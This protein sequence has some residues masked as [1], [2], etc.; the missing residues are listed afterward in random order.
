MSTP[1]K[2]STNW[3]I[4]SPKSRTRSTLRRP[5]D[6]Q[7]GYHATAQEGLPRPG[8]PDHRRHGGYRAE[9]ALCPRRRG[10][11]QRRGPARRL[12][13]SQAAAADL[14]TTGTKKPGENL[15]GDKLSVNVDR[16]YKGI[17]RLVTAP[18]QHT[19]QPAFHRGLRPGQHQSRPGLPVRG[20]GSLA[21]SERLA[22]PHPAQQAAVRSPAATQPSHHEAPRGSGSSSR[23]S[24]SWAQAYPDHWKAHARFAM[25]RMAACY[26]R[27]G[28]RTSSG[29]ATWL[30]DGPKGGE[31]PLLTVIRG[32]KTGQGCTEK[33]PVVETVEPDSG[34]SNAVGRVY[35]TSPVIQGARY[36]SSPRL[37]AFS[38]RPERPN[39]R[40]SSR[41][42][43]SGAKPW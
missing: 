2:S 22:Q 20:A 8:W 17:R 4:R 10:A 7:G 39:R 37:A 31:W 1:E 29:R 42:T 21:E 9:A 12:V 30:S 16:K 13:A 15:L 24:P 33:Q 5:G 23:P 40:A 34:K 32:K 11:A 19:R 26:N 36:S 27:G 6:L 41:N 18:S 3:G 14:H 38:S 25:M 43:S 35:R 28:W